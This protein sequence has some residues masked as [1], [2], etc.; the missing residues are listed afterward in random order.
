MTISLVTLKT[1]QTLIADVDSNSSV[2]DYVLK[3][4]VQ[5]IIQPSKD[6]PMMAFVPFLEFAE[7]FKPGIKIKKSDVLTVTTPV[8]ELHNR[9]NQMFG[10]GIEIASSIPKA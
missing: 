9:Y 5:V 7:D 1:A 10:S 2:D 6:G 8:R 3:Q 4:P